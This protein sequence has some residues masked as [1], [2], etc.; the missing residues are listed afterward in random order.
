MTGVILCGGKGERLKPLTSVKPKALLE[1]QADYTILDKQLLQFKYAGIE[2][3]VLLC[4]KS[5]EPFERYKGKYGL[6]IS[7]F[8]DPPGSG[9]LSPIAWFISLYGECFP[10]ILRNGDVVT[11]VNLRE[12]IEFHQIH[13]NK[14][15]ML[16]TS[17]LSPYG[18]L[19]ISGR[20]VVK[21]VEKPLLQ[22]KIN[23]GIYIFGE[24]IKDE[25]KKLVKEGNL[26]GNI[27]DRFFPE[28]A[29][30]GKIKVYEE[31]TFWR[32]VETVKDYEAV[33][34]EYQK[35]L[36]KPWGYEKILAFQEG[37]YLSKEMYIMKGYSTS[38]HYHNEKDETIHC[39]K[40]EVTISFGREDLVL[41]PGDSLRIEPRREHTIFAVKNSVL[42]EYSTPHL[43]DTVRVKDFYERSKDGSF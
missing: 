3:I 10:L 1:L 13:E 26:K 21:F 30:R 24:E 32:S 11:D 23:G 39:L 33:L 15:T 34:K 14:I 18:V 31:D 8:L 19:E 41:F 16:S 37:K 38:R 4:G 29:Y 25:F 6:D 17:L 35:R 5:K 2:K 27:E 40:G 9:T 12:M 20:E 36:D 42:F 43:K 7:F 28:M 22:K